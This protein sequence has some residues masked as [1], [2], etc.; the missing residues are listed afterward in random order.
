M[1][2]DLIVESIEEIKTETMEK[3][4]ELEELLGGG[5]EEGTPQWKNTTPEL[6]QRYDDEW[7][8]TME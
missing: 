3:E 5:M 7:S 2:F 6:A 8:G 4:T 1:V